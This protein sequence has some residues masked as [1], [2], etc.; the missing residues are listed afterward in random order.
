MT[1]KRVVQQST[2]TGKTWIPQPRQ[3]RVLSC[4]ADEILYGG[5]AGCGKTF[6]LLLDYL[7]HKEKYANQVHGLLLRR[8]YP[9]FQQIL[10]DSKEVFGSLYGISA[11]KDAE[12]QWKFPDGATLRLGYLDSEDDIYQYQGLEFQWCA[13]DE[14]SQW[15][16]DYSY[17]WLWSRLRSPHG[18]PSRRINTS[19]PGGPGHNWVKEYF[20][21][22]EFPQG[23]IPIEE[24]FKLSEKET[25]KRTR[26]FIPGKLKD[27]A[28]LSRDGSYVAN[29][30]MLP[31][32]QRKMYLEGSWD[33]AEGCFFSEWDSTAHVCHPFDI[34]EDW[35]KWMALDW[36][37]RKPYCV[38]WF[39]E[40]PEGIIYVYRELYGIKRDPKTMRIKNDAG[41]GEPA[42]L[43]AQRIRQ[44]EAD[45]AEW[46]VERYA[47][48]SIFDKSGHETTIAQEFAK[49]GVHLNASHKANKAGSINRFREKLK[50]VNGTAGIRFFNTCRNSIRTIPSLPIEA[51]NGE[52]YDSGAE[53]H[54]ADCVIYGLR[55]NRSDLSLTQREAVASISKKRLAQFGAYGAQ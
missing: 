23:E 24:E 22:D 39:T 17:Q 48:R 35:A 10:R 52:Q 41:T 31:E 1:T 38:L 37:T 26:I 21:I 51:N 33:V 43:V 28:Y 47:D 11:W 8:T 40:S 53:D 55:K 27:N 34:P 29:L 16:S 54:A 20:R 49:N 6:L 13:Y 3:M 45:A 14:L 46:I 19:N 7:A 5:A 25:I 4:P 30:M 15:A 36:G 42:S 9:E 50:V 2:N 44:L 12:K 32:H 18:V